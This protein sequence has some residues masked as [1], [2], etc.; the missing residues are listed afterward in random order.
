MKKYILILLIIFPFISEA[1]TIKGFVYGNDIDGKQALPGVNI[2]WQGTTQG[3]ASQP[4]GSF[5]IKNIGGHN[6][7]VFSFVGYEQKQ[8]QINGSESIEVIL[9]PNLELEEVTVIEKNRGTYLSV[10]NPIQTENI[11]GA[12]LH[13]AA[14]C[15]LAESFETNPSVDVSYSD[16][17]TGAKQ[18]K[19]LG[20]DGTYSQLQVENLPNL[21]GLATTFGLTYI[22]GPWLES[23]QVSKGAASVLNGYESIAGQINAEIKKPDSEEKLF[24]NLYQSAEGRQEFNGNG[25]IRFNDK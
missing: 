3:T 18:I 5:E 16:A 17:V 24:L 10:I 15:N 22:P 23:I 11:N 8:I 1:Q 19:L 12:E 9:E 25:N 21:R 6:V 4:D 20:L 13:K 7:L 14:C 2:V